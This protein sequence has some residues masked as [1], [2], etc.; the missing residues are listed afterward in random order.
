M[1]CQVHIFKRAQ[2]SEK[3]VH[4]ARTLT[5]ENLAFSLDGALYAQV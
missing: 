2:Y 3:V 4:S 5:F 1:C